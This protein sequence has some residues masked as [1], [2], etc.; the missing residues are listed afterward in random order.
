MGSKY[1]G[2]SE[3]FYIDCIKKGDTKFDEEEMTDIPH[4]QNDV[5]GIPIF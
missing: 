5:N 2:S 3:K 4:Y 1:R